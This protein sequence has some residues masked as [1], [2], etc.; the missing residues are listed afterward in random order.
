MS[1]LKVERIVTGALETNSYVARGEDGHGFIV[2]ANGDATIFDRFISEC[3]VEYVDALLLTHGHFD[4]I[5][6]AAYY[7]KKGI[8]VY[9]HRADAEKLYTYKNLGAFAGNTVEYLHADVL[10]D[11]GEKLSLAG[12]E[13]KVMHTAGHSE[14][15]V[16]YITES[17]IFVGDTLFKL[18]YGRTDF[19]DGSSEKLLDSVN[20][21]FA[22]PNNPTLYTGHGDLTTLDYERKYNPVIIDLGKL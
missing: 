6:L 22:L 13:V 5:G 10:L 15:S 9:I 3:G 21:L 4:H 2:D 20:R 7:Q 14:G 17:G 16:S 1:C 8:K 19:Y 18:S 11:G 12:T